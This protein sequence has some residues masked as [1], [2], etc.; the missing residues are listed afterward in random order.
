MGNDRI[1]PETIIMLSN[2]DLGDEVSPKQ[3]ND[4]IKDLY[5][6][7]FFKN[8]E[9]NLENNILKFYIEENPII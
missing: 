6:S 7:N 2:I 3:I 4:L 5:E 8:I 1:P 9:I